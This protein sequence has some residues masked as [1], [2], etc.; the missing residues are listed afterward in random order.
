[1]ARADRET[2]GGTG[3]RILVVED[4]EIMAE[5]VALGLRRRGHAV[6]VVRD[7]ADA[8]EWAAVNRYDVIVLDRDLPVVHG[9]DVCRQL[10]ATGAQS[11]VLMLTAASAVGDRVQ[12]LELG[13]DDYLVKPFAFDELLARVAALGRRTAPAHP[14]TVQVGDLSVDTARRLASRAGRALD[15]T[16]KE[17]GMLEVLATAQGRVVSAEELL[18][19]VW[20][21]NADPFTNAVRVTMVGLRR[22]LGEP[23]IDTLRGQGYR[24]ATS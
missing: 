20:D 19:R 10:V 6:D 7:G 16:P 18:E 9:D 3:V 23:G 22:K 4:E 11:R 15:L 24:L 17:F 12:G 14:P 2:E 13:A 1:M 5:M 21:T 8:L